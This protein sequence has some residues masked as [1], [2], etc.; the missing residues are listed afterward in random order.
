MVEDSKCHMKC[1]GNPDETCGGDGAINIYQD[2]TFLPVSEATVEEYVAL[3]CHE[4]NVNGGRA[5]F[6]RQ[7]QLD[8][9]TMTTK[10]CLNACLAGGF[11]FAGTEYGGGQYTFN[12]MTSQEVLTLTH[13]D[14]QSVTAVWFWATARPR[15]RTP[16]ARCRV[17]GRLTRSVAGRR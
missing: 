11:P 1:S 4:D 17:R 2:P 16:A 10:T 8:D 13:M 12:S 6:Y 3:G 7:D 14:S 9:S 5:V 15:S